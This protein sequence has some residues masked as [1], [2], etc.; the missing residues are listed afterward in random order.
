MTTRSSAS[1]SLRNRKHDVCSLLAAAACG[2]GA[3]GGLFMQGAV[4]EMRLRC[5]FSSSSKCSK[6]I[7]TGRHHFVSLTFG[8]GF[9]SQACAF[10]ARQGAHQRTTTEWAAAHQRPARSDLSTP[11]APGASQAARSIPHPVGGGG[12]CRAC[13]CRVPFNVDYRGE[14]GP[15]L[16]GSGDAGRLR[17]EIVEQTPVHAL[18][19]GRTAS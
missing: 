19:A 5:H 18:G 10:A 9:R 3:C 1:I 15:R 7:Y 4:R 12:V 2:G 17:P 8:R 14:R 13:S 11:F 16:R 6:T